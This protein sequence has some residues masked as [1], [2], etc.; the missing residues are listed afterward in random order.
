[1]VLDGLI[2]ATTRGSTGSCRGPTTRAAE[3]RACPSCS[4]DVAYQRHPSNHRDIHEAWPTSHREWSNA[5]VKDAKWLIEW[6]RRNNLSDTQAAD[7][8]GM[9]LGT[10]RNKR[11][12]RSKISVTLA[13]LVV[14]TEVVRPNWLLIAEIGTRLGVIEKVKTIEF[15]RKK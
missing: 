4:G 14:L 5:L 15:S 13:K 8:L 7:E 12:G 1:M 10:Y 9:P 6:Q 11:S 2:N 3:R